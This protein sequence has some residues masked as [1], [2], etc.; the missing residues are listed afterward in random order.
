MNM[1][2]ED[3][4]DEA[5]KSLER[6]LNDMNLSLNKHKNFKKFFWTPDLNVC[7]FA[8]QNEIKHTI[9]EWGKINK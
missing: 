5:L 2:I 6:N 8:T 7:G 9:T 4:R 3:G 1:R